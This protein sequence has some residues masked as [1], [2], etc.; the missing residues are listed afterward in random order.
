M[1]SA[2][3]T[4]TELFLDL[5]QSSDCSCPFLAAIVWLFKE[6]FIVLSWQNW[7]FIFDG[8]QIYE[9]VVASLTIGL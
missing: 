1:I 4:S 7:H 9:G 5:D 2:D 6:G 8:V 3:S